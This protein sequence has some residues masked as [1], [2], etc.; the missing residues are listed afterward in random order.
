MAE[1]YSEISQGTTPPSELREMRRNDAQDEAGRIRRAERRTNEAAEKVV[2]KRH[3]SNELVFW[4]QR[5]RQKKKTKQKKKQQK[6]TTKNVIHC[7]HMHSTGTRTKTH[8][9]TRLHSRI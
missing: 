1:M 3:P 4:T 5:Y 7:I 8:T 6:K 2:A 9:R